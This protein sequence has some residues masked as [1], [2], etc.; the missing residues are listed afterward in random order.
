[1]DFCPCISIFYPLTLLFIRSES[2]NGRRSDSTNPEDDVCLGSMKIDEEG[3]AIFSPRIERSKPPQCRNISHQRNNANKPERT[4]RDRNKPPPTQHTGA[5]T[6]TQSSNASGL[7]LGGL[8]ER[9]VR[10]TC[11]QSA[12][13]VGVDDLQAVNV[14]GIDP[15]EP[16]YTSVSVTSGLERWHPAAYPSRATPLKSIPWLPYSTSTL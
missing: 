6:E 9:L 16:V 3:I 15:A 4:V 2:R 1:M 11:P 8:L 10:R 5:R 14:A 12:L 13:H 7:Y